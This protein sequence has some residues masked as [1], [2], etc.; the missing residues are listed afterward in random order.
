MIERDGY[1]LELARDGRR[2]VLGAPD[3]RH[4]LSIG[5]LSSFDRD[6][7]ADETVSFESSEDGASIVLTRVSTAWERAGTTVT[8]APDRIEIRSFVEGAGR[9]TDVH[10]LGGRGVFGPMTG[11]FRTGT[12][13]TIVGSSD[14]NAMGK[15]YVDEANAEV[16]VTKA[17]VGTLSVGTTALVLKEAKPLPASD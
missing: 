7:T 4:W 16:L 8:C 5:L 14:G 15:R 1:R 12:S 13:C 3:G 17:G 10:L 2:A 11:L 9:L 6:G